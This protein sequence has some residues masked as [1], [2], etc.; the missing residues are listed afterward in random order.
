MVVGGSGRVGASGARD[1]RQ[2][3]VLAGD[4]GVHREAADLVPLRGVPDHRLLPM[5]DQMAP[6][7]SPNKGIPRRE[8]GMGPIAMFSLHPFSPIFVLFNY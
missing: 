3:G 6:S 1:G 7:L 8:S 2:R 5:R 4:R